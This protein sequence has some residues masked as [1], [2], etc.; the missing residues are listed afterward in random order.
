M[1]Q[2]SFYQSFLRRS[3]SLGAPLVKTSRS[4][5]DES[6][7]NYRTFIYCRYLFLRSALLACITHCHYATSR[8]CISAYCRWCNFVRASLRFASVDA[9]CGMNCWMLGCTL[10]CD[11]FYTQTHHQYLTLDAHHYSDSRRQGSREN[12]AGATGAQPAPK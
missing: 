9:G 2:A 4:M 5:T 12:R 3:S 6:L 11:C 8:Y 7:L 1:I 10:F